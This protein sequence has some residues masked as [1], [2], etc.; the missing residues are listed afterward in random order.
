MTT[1]HD[2]A[3]VLPDAPSGSCATPFT[4]VLATWSFTGQSGSEASATASSTAHGVTTGAFTRASTLTA[5]SGSGSINSSNWTTSAQPDVTKYYSLSITPPSGCSL[6][7]TSLSIDAKSSSTGPSS[8]SAAT[9]AD[10]YAHMASVTANAVSTPALA[11]TGATGAVEIRIYGYG[12]TGTSGTMRVE[13]TF[14]VTG[15]IH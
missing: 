9:S 1:Q 5:T 10:S 13:N 12:A 8:M 15:S 7:L 2:A 11:V 14:T 3:T 6:D 4:G